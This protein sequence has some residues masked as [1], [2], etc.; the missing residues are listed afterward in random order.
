MT[1]DES[2]G[3]KRCFRCHPSFN[4][5]PHAENFPTS[6]SI[7]PECS[8]LLLLILPSLLVLDSLASSEPHFTL[9]S[10]KVSHRRAQCH[11]RC[12]PAGV[13]SCGLPAAP[14]S[15]NAS[16]PGVAPFSPSLV[17]RACL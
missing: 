4:P 5:I 17:R 11:L 10:S 15:R 16:L 13:D 3:K 2:V 8:L 7:C 1:R 6:R 14:A 9:F 12:R